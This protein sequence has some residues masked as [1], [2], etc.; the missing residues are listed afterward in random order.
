MS[1]SFWFRLIIAF[2]GLAALIYM[3]RKAGAKRFFTAFGIGH[4]L[5]IIIMACI[6]VSGSIDAQHQLFWILPGTVDL[7]IS[8][9]VDILAP[10][11]MALYIF[12]LATLGSVQYAV[13]GWFIDYKLSKD[14]KAL[15]PSKLFI[16]IGVAALIG[17]VYWTYTSV[18]YMRLPKYAK[19]EIQ[20]KKAVTALDRA[21]ALRDAAKAYFEV[22]KYDEAR[23]Y[24]EQLLSLL[25]ENPKDDIVVIYGGAFYDSHMVLGRID[26]INGKPE[27]AIE[28]LFEAAK[29]PGD[30]ALASFGP[31]MCLAKELLEKGYKKPVITFLINCKR[32]WKFEEGKI[33]KWLNEINA[34]LIP[35]FGL[36]LII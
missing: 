21:E 5:F 17:L 14:R 29:T 19:A 18:S 16:I 34:G 26:L 22:K 7:P 12:L 24:A 13:I 6:Y 36:N 9:L 11:S 3:V 15:K 28:H 30:A 25:R 27:L 10:Y 2:L 35:D 20:L 33:D 1:S 23:K 4:F 8:L 32:F 31:N